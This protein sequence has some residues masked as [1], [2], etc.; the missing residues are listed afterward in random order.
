MDQKTNNNNDDNFEVFACPLFLEDGQRCNYDSPREHNLKRHIKETHNGEK[1]ECKCGKLMTVSSIQRH[2]RESCP[3]RAN[4]DK[5]SKVQKIRSNSKKKKVQGK[6]VSSTVVDSEN[7]EVTEY[8]LATKVKVIK[9]ENGHIQVVPYVTHYNIDDLTIT[10][11]ATCSSKIVP[12]APNEMS[13]DS[14]DEMVSNDVFLSSSS[15]DGN[16]NEHFSLEMKIYFPNT[17]SFLH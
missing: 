6:Q 17:L 14:S 16:S 4:I 1:I 11:N 13:S 3:L 2:K 15:C 8:S 7:G 5:R 12:S 9:F 10:V